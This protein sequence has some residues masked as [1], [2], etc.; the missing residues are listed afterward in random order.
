MGSYF[1][2]E[3]E[4]IGEKKPKKK[5][6]LKKLILMIALLVIVGGVVLF[7]AITGCSRAPKADIA[8]DVET[9]TVTDSCGREVEIPKEITRVA[10]SGA[11]AQ[12][13][14]ETIAPEKLVGLSASFSTNQR[15]FFPE[16]QWYMPTFGQFYGSKSTLNMETLIAEDPQIIIDIGDKKITHKADMNSIQRQTGIPTI[17]I[18]TSMDTFPDAYR[19]LGEIL[20][21]EAEGEEMAEYVEKTINTARANAEKIPEKDRKS[22]MYGTSSTGLACNA[23]GSVQADVIETVGA[24]NA[25]KVPEDEITNAGGGSLVNMEEVYNA[26]PDV[27][28]FTEGGPYSRIREG[29]SEWAELKAVKNG[30]Y[31]EIPGLP[32]C[33][34]SGPPSI[35]RI[36]GIWWLGNLLYPEVYDVDMVEKAQEF[37]KLFYRYDLSEQEAKQMMANSVF[38][39]KGQ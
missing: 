11:T 19:Q 20:G 23:E 24:A 2:F 27:I 39:K 4:G 22:V 21:H 34:M 13:V 6:N 33:W 38:D 37:Y 25:I 9:V 1:N 3:E 36:L 16:E 31:Y 10:P 30:E 5:R 28:I 32:Y 14:L 15:K 26:E 18:E 8:P 29:G 7:F 17:F 35:N 12:M